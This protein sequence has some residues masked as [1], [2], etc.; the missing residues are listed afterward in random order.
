MDLNVQAFRIVEEATK[1][2]TSADKRSKEALRRGGVAGAAARLKTTNPKR[3]LEIAMQANAARWK[4]G[5]AK[6]Q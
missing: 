4:K 2:T 5:R 3:R 6:T 1:E